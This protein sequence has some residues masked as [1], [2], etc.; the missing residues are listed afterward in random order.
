MSLIIPSEARLGFVRQIGEI[1]SGDFRNGV[2][3][4]VRDNLGIL[5]IIKDGQKFYEVELGE[6]QTADMAEFWRQAS[7]MLSKAGGSGLEPT[8]I[9]TAK[10]V[11]TED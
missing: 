2:S 10:S 11:P 9:V 7:D 5:R 8:K 3:V 6:K 4:Y 1:L